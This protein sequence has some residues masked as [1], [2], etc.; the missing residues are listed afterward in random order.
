MQ[1]FLV[2]GLKPHQKTPLETSLEVTFQNENQE[3]NT[4]TFYAKEAKKD[5]MLQPK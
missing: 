2:G 5:I 1:I 3:Q 4:L